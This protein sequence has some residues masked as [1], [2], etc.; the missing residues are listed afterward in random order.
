VLLELDGLV[1]T[2]GMRPTGVLH[3][4]AHEGEEA[5]I[6][7]RCGID[8]VVWVEGNPELVERLRARVAPRG[9]DV[10]QALLSDVEGEVVSFH[11]TNSSQSSSILEL[12]TH[13][14]SHPD[15]HVTHTLELATTTVDSLSSEHD[16]AGL[17]FM[18]LDLQGAELKALRGAIR[19]LCHIDYVYTEV[20]KEPVYQGCALIGELDGFL[21]EQG[22]RRVATTWTPEAWGDALYVRG[23]VGPLRRLAGYLRYGDLPVRVR[24]AIK[25][26]RA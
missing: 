24:E 22:F 17:N 21:G 18:N 26:R 6:Y 15:I 8:R 16:F 23:G 5:G 19:S 4:G 12:G 11:V 3:L 2:F 9:H 25:A 10:C 13:R 14:A 1:R 20:N 7:E